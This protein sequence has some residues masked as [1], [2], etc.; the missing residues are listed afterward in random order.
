[1]RSASQRASSRCDTGTLDETRVSPSLRR[2][3]AS[4]RPR[5]CGIETIRG[6]GIRVSFDQISACVGPPKIETTNKHW[7]MTE[8][9]EPPF[10]FQFQGRAT[11]ADCRAGGDCS[12]SIGTIILIILVI[13]L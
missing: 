11:G 4:S 5:R 12:V 2:R 3:V 7:N 9:S 8:L 1:M 10:V 13:A 6:A